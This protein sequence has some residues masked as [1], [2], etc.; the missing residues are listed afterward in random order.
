MPQRNSGFWAKARQA[1]NKLVKQFL[2]HPDVMLIDIGYV[3]ENDKT[4]ENIA[5]RIHVHERWFKAKPEERIAFPEQVDG[6][7]VAIIPGEY[8]AGE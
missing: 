4:S 1:Q 3:D 5:L 6:I 7:S 8:R 2:E